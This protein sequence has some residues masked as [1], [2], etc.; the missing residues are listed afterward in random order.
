MSNTCMGR[1]TNPILT[2]C[3]TKHVLIITRFETTKPNHAKHPA[4]CTRNCQKR[5][6]QRGILV[7]DQFLSIAS[8]SA[9]R[10]HHTT[11]EELRYTNAVKSTGHWSTLRR[12]SQIFR[13]WIL[14]HLNY[15]CILHTCRLWW[16]K[17]CI[18]M[19]YQCTSISYSSMC[20]VVY[21]SQCGILITKLHFNWLYNPNCEVWWNGYIFAM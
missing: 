21:K 18:K 9:N 1:F 2:Y 12:W 15:S 14:R 20:I 6:A 10:G 5:C 16:I 19:V 11:E 4:L 13:P 8:D 3:S 7:A 17:A